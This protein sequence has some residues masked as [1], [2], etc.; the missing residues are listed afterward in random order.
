MQVRQRGALQHKQSPGRPSF[1]IPPL[2]ANSAHA[3]EICTRT[4]T[5]YTIDIKT[6]K[7]NEL[8]QEN[9]RMQV[10]RRDALQ[11]NK[12]HWRPPCTVKVR[13]KELFFASSV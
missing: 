2:L 9:K 8:A 12:S 10:R 13:E 7:A 1:A 3:Q 6:N 11:H 5:N 4:R